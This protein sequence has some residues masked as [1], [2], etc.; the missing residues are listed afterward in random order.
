MVE[1][2]NRHQ[3]E[4]WFEDKP[5][6]VVATI[7]LRAGL[8]LAPTLAFWFRPI[9]DPAESPEV[10]LRIL[11]EY[12]SMVQEIVPG[13]SS[14]V[15]YPAASN[16]ALLADADSQVGDSQFAWSALSQEVTYWQK[17]R[18]KDDLWAKPLW[19]DGI[20]PEAMEPTWLELLQYFAEDQG[21]WGFWTRLI[22]KTLPGLAPNWD[23]LLEI[24]TSDEVDWNAKHVEVL[25]AI[26]AIEA[27][28]LRV[29]PHEEAIDAERQRAKAGLEKQVTRLLERPMATE[30]NAVGLANQI[31][32]ALENYCR[33]TGAN[34]VPEEF[35]PIISIGKI[36]RT[37]GG[38]LAQTR[39]ERRSSEK[40][41]DEMEKQIVELNLRIKELELELQ[42]AKLK[43]VTGLISSS[44]ISALTGA[45]AS[46][47]I[48]TSVLM[49]S[50]EYEPRDEEDLARVFKDYLESKVVEGSVEPPQ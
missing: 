19:P 8:R 12:I 50:P 27:K 36:L 46:A 33:E 7:A 38:E 48:T 2:T 5:R 4:A 1:I 14:P 35:L 24:A 49:L 13:E 23:L 45:V 9:H 28:Y 22:K 40:T 44:A 42:E 10:A 3:L 15:E 11:R 25:E 30:F 43:S 39:L 6:I 17:S 26:A 20:W 32:A 34:I 37:L 29:S 16:Y 41:H 18:F 47:V 31:D 21:D